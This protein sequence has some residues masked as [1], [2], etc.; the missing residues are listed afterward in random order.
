MGLTYAQLKQ[1]N[2]TPLS[3]AVGK[4]RNLPGQIDVIATSFDT[5]VTKGLQDSDWTGETADA[6]FTGF[7]A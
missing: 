7:G 5:T 4:W 6:A 2:L 1:A 3:E